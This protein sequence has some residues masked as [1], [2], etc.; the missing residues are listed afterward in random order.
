MFTGRP[1][2]RLHHS[3]YSRRDLQY[4]G[5]SFPSVFKTL[6]Q[7]YQKSLI[8][9]LMETMSFLW[10]P[11]M[12]AALTIHSYCELQL[13]YISIY[14]K[15]LYCFIE[16]F[17]IYPQ[18]ND[19]WCIIFFVFENMYCCIYFLLQNKINKIALLL[20]LDVLV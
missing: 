10:K 15:K 7:Q 17:V 9:S 6:G 4:L 19:E 12:F 18:I 8:R 16:I 3:A 5:F 13:S 20:N 11:Q 2:K 14:W 1:I